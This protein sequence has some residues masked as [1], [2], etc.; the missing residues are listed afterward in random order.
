[1]GTLA[2]WEAAVARHGAAGFSTSRRRHRRHRA[3]DL[4]RF[5]DRV[6]RVAG[7]LGI[8]PGDTVHL[9]L[10]NCPAFVAVAR[11]R[12]GGA[13]IVPAGS[14]RATGGGVAEQIRALRPAVG[15]GA[16]AWRGAVPGRR[17]GAPAS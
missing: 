4:H 1:M 17:P 3:L 6:A 5:D 12:A 13:R 14:P 7:G 2:G 16:A 10:G 8:G 9:A 11:R 15:V